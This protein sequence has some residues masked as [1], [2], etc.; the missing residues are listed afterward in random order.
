MGGFVDYLPEDKS[1]ALMAEI[2]DAL[3]NLRI[4]SYAQ[5]KA[6]VAKLVAKFDDEMLVEL[7]KASLE[8]PELMREVC[9]VAEN[10]PAESLEQMAR[11]RDR[12]SEA[13]QSQLYEYARANGFSALADLYDIYR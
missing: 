5:N 13:E 2:P 4:S 7:T 11:L 6:L 1:F 8:A 3:S 9:L 12:F 10:L